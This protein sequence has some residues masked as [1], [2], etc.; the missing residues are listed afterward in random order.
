M[1]LNRLEPLR[2]ESVSGP[3]VGGAARRMKMAK[4]TVSENGLSLSSLLTPLAS[5]GKGLNTQPSTP[6]RSSGNTS[7]VTPCSTL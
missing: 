5:S 6:A 3:G 4:F 2:V 1:V 7:L